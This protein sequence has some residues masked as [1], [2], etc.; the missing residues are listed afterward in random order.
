MVMVG[1]FEVQ[2]IYDGSV[3]FHYPQTPHSLTPFLVKRPIHFTSFI[4]SFLTN[5]V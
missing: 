5:H 3:F 1:Y 4:I 2:V